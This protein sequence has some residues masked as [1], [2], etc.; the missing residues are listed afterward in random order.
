MNTKT[1]INFKGVITFKNIEEIAKNIDEILA[2][3][4]AITFIDYDITTEYAHRPRINQRLG[5]DGVSVRDRDNRTVKTI[6]ISLRD[7]LHPVH[8]RSDSTSEYPYVELASNRVEI[9]FK[10]DSTTIRKWEF[11]AHG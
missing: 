2:Q 1:G 7:Y 10:I 3:A 6:M 8:V 11:I 4:I 5:K 9:T